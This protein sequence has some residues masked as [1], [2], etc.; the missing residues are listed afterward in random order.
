MTAT[1]AAPRQDSTPS[2]LA[3]Y[4]GAVW[5]VSLTLAYA[6]LAT[7]TVLISGAEPTLLAFVGG[8]RGLQPWVPAEMPSRSRAV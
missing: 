8:F 1:A 3:G 5:Y 7:A 6:A 2:S 4:M